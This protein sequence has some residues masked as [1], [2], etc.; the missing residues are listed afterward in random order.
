[1]QFLKPLIAAGESVAEA[2]SNAAAG[3]D[4]AAT[5]SGTGA[6]QGGLGGTLMMVGYLVV[7]VG[8]LYFVMIRPQ[9]K[10]TKK[11]KE[12]RENIQVGDE[13]V[14]VGG[15][16]GRVVSLKEDSVIVESPADR[17]KH[18]IA[19]WAIQQNMTVHDN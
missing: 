14:T 8:V 16:Y 3:T 2:V 1:M 7:I 11:E 17:S 5:S 9:R 6:D 12:L 13:I 10:R 4:S 19:K 18:R 15:I